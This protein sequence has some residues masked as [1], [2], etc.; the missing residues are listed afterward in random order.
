ML[1]TVRQIIRDNYNIV[2]VSSDDLTYESGVVNMYDDDVAYD[3]ETEYGYIPEEILTRNYMG[4]RADKFF[5]FYKKY[6]VQ[7]DKLKP[8]RGHYSILKL[9]QIGKLR[10]VI[11]KSYYGLIQMTGVSNIIELR[12]TI[13]INVCPACGK[14]YSAEYVANSIEE[15]RCEHCMMILKPKI[16]LYGDTID[17][18]LMSRAADHISNANVLL[19]VGDV[20]KDTFNRRQLSY[21]QGDK[22]IFIKKEYHDTDEMANYCLYGECQS[23]LPQIIE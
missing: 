23:I 12:G 19:V 17:N 20:A 16:A 11:T 22:M 1:Q 14:R 9:Q 8:N 2:V 18:G 21:Y 10:A 3:I 6:V 15:P 5:E 13:H 7:F 4:R